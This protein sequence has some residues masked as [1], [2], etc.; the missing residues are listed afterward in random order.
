MDGA[1]KSG[2]GLIGGVVLKRIKYKQ[3]AFTRY[4]WRPVKDALNK[5][6]VERKQLHKRIFKNARQ[7]RCMGK[8]KIVA[9]ELGHT[10]GE[11]KW[12]SR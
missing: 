3:V 7:V 12:W 6:R 4:I 5:Y 8:D 2:E 11:R 9:E 10:F 1:T